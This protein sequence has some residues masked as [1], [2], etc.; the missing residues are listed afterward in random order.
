VIDALDVP[1]GVTI[2][3][4]DDL[5]AGFFSTEPQAEQWKSA[6][7]AN[8]A[9]S[10]VYNGSAD[11]C[12]KT[13][14]AGAACNF[15]WTYQKLYS[16]AGGARTEVLPQVYLGYMATEWAEIDRTGGGALHF[17]GALTEHALAS[18]TLTPVQGYTAL[19]RAVSSVTTRAV[20]ARVADIDT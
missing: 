8:T 4:A 7:L 2:A 6:Y 12:P 3:G 5:E 13:W 11:F 18:G 1:P 14:T 10:L 20:D 9:A 15:G 19:V 16:L 17:V